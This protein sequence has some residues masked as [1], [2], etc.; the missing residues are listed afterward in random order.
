MGRGRLRAAEEAGVIDEDTYVQQGRDL[1]RAYSTQVINYILGTLQPDTELAMVG[2][3]FTDEVSHQFMGLVTPND[4]DG[5]PN[6]CYDVTPKF[7]DI[8]ARAATAGRVAIREGYIQSAYA[9]PTRSSR[10]RA[11]LMGGDPTTFAGSDHGFGAA[12]LRGQ[13]QQG[14]VRRDCPRHVVEHGRLAPREQRERLELPA[15]PTTDLAKA[16]WAG[17]TIQIYV[18]TDAA[19][20]AITYEAVRA[21]S[22]TRSRT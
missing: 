4:P 13:R 10:S 11:Q 21:A 17:G 12:A 6:P 5:S 16:C 18:N 22:R 8:S 7:D 1:E 2:Y 14:A 20:P 9:T 3:P 15:P 19:R